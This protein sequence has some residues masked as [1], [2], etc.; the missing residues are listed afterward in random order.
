MSA[1][2]C[3]CDVSWDTG[4]YFYFWRNSHINMLCVLL[5]SLWYI[6]LYFAL[7]CSTFVAHP[8]RQ[9]ALGAFD[10]YEPVPRPAWSHFPSWPNQLQASYQQVRQLSP[11]PTYPGHLFPNMPGA[12]FEWWQHH[13]TWYPSGLLWVHTLLR[14]WLKRRPIREYTPHLALRS[15]PL[16]FSPH[17]HS[18]RFAN[19]DCIDSTLNYMTFKWQFH[20][21]AI[22]A[23]TQSWLSAVSIPIT[24]HDRRDRSWQPDRVVSISILMEACRVRRYRM[25]DETIPE[26]VEAS[27]YALYLICGHTM[28]CSTLKIVG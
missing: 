20:V 4:C 8:P 26:E 28:S 6:H 16:L 22:E 14:A 13:V 10:W 27:L 3:F 18:F 1:V 11:P 19:P 5:F 15:K 17:S 21:I 12:S 23:Y 25:A 24:P 9:Y 2:I 7:R